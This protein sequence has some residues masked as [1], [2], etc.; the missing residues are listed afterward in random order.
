M[1]KIMV[2]GITS[3]FLLFTGCMSESDKNSEVIDNQK[4]EI[5]QL[6]NNISNLKTQEKQLQNSVIAKK[7]EN[8]I[9]K[10]IVTLNIKQSHFTLDIGEHVKDS[11]NDIDIQIPVDKEFYESVKEGDILNDS[12]RFGSLLIGGSIGNWNIKVSSKEVK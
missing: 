6:D 12:F 1:K 9:A 7:E 5:Q 3:L 10:Y 4:N 11:M 8:G 2:L